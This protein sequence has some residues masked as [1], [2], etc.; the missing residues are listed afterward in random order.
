MADLS[1]GDKLGIFA[2]LLAYPL[3]V[4]AHLTTPMWRNWIA[5]RS[6]GSLINR[7]ST[8]EKTLAELETNPVI[9]E[10][11]NQIFWEITRVRITVLYATSA[12]VLVIYLGIRAVADTNTTAFHDF[13]MWVGFVVMVTVIMMLRE[14]Y[15][16]DFRY[17][18]SAKRRENLREAIE[19]LKHLRD[20]WG[21][22]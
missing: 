17:K 22:P 11:Q 15:G 20:N 13:S 7:I 14:R 8:L 18:R 6:L 1:F 5:K 16:R 4:I 2:L 21:K 10:V 19:N 12:V 9:D 3:D